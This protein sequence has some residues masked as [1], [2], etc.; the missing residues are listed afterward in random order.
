MPAKRFSVAAHQASGS[1]VK[2]ARKTEKTAGPG[3]A[4]V[5]AVVRPWG[6]A[7]SA[8]TEGASWALMRCGFGNA[9]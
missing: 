9:S 3:P 8:F 2:A 7:F 6:K 1:L 5:I 4:T